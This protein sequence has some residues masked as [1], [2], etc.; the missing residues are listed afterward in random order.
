MLSLTDPD[1]LSWTFAG[2][3]PDNWQLQS[4]ADGVSSWTDE[5][6]LPGATFE[7]APAPNLLF[8]RV[9]ALE[10]VD[11]VSGYSNVVHM[12]NG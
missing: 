9:F 8:W 6:V 5:D 4:S 12:T 11:R 1:T 2:P 10:G 7:F 3:V